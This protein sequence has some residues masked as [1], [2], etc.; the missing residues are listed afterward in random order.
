MLGVQAFIALEYELRCLKLKTIRT[1][2]NT[3]QRGR[4]CQSQD[5][6]AKDMWPCSASTES[7]S[8]QNLFLYSYHYLII[9]SLLFQPPI[10]SLPSLGTSSSTNVLGSH[11]LKWPHNLLYPTS[12][13]KLILPYFTSSQAIYLLKQDCHLE[14]QGQLSHPILIKLKI[15]FK[16]QS[17]TNSI[18]V[19]VPVPDDMNSPN[20]CW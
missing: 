10:A 17:T 16:C 3:H 1:Q 9:L 14:L 12:K 4:C 8:S 15:Q 11:T 2:R 19:Q 20:V 18:K 5:Q 7:K 13:C 6:S